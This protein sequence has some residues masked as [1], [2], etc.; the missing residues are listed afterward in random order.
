[1]VQFARTNGDCRRTEY[2]CWRPGPLGRFVKIIAASSTSGVFWRGCC[3]LSWIV[4]GGRGR[5]VF[6][7]GCW[8]QV[9]ISSVCR[10]FDPKYPANCLSGSSL[11]ILFCFHADSSRLLLYC[12]VSLLRATAASSVPLLCTKP[13]CW[14]SRHA[15]SSAFANANRFFAMGSTN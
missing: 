6:L 11:L 9:F 4:C 5:F 15:R 7:D 13:C 8:L 10:R 1:M 3:V 2:A 12:L 14:A